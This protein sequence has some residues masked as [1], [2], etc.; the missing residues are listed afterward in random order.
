[1][2]VAVVALLIVGWWL[3]SPLFIDKEVD[4]AFP[5]A[6]ESNASTEPNE[7]TA[8]NKDTGESS[9]Q[10]ETPSPILAGEFEEVDNVHSIEG[11]AEVFESEDGNIL[12]LSE[13]A[14]TNRPDLYVYLVK[15]GQE[16]KDGTSLGTLKGNKGN[17]NYEIPVQLTVEE[18]DRI[19]IWC[20]AFGVSFGHAQ[21]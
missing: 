18:G 14:T 9:A 21:F 8:P 12:R 2:S 5:V 15:D 19:V 13:F 4:E 17:Q 6:T 11:N 3:L 10:E 7:E 1:M 20:K 16:T